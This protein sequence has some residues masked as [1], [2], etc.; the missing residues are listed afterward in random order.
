MTKLT[1][2]LA[3]AGLT[4]MLGSASATA[5]VLITLEQDGFGSGPIKVVSEDGKRWSKILDG[6][7]T[8]P[9]KIYLGISKGWFVT[10]GIYQPGTKI[11][12][13]GKSTREW[14]Q[15]SRTVTGST[16]HLG[17]I[18]AMGIIS[19]C[20]D[21]LNDGGAIGQ[22]QTFW[23]AVELELVGR[24]AMTN[25]D[26]YPPYS[27]YGSVLVPVECLPV[28]RTGE[29]ADGDG[30][31]PNTTPPSIKEA[32]LFLTTINGG[33]NQGVTMGACPVLETTVRFETDK[34]G[35]LSFDL[36]R[37][38]GG[39]TSHTINASFDASAGK[40]YA[41]YQKQEEFKATTN[42]QYMA[43][44]TTPLGGNTGWEDITIHCGGGLADPTS[45][46]P[47]D[48]LPPMQLKGDFNFTAD[49]TTAC[50]RK[51]KALIAFSTSVKNDVHYSL[52][53][54]NGHFSG[55]AQPVPKPGGGYVAPAVATFDI[56]ETTQVTCVLKSVAPGAPKVHTGKAHEYQCV[57]TTG[58][59]GSD[60]LMPGTRPDPQKPG[61]PGKFVADPPRKPEGPK[62]ENG[63]TDAPKLVCANGVVSGDACS[64]ARTDKKVKVG[65]NA[66]RCVQSVVDPKPVK[67]TV[68]EPKISCSGGTVTNGAC[69]CAR[70]HKPVKAG[71]NA[72][73]CLAADPP[74]NKDASKF[75]LKTASKKPTQPNPGISDKP[76]GETGKGKTAKKG[77]GG[78]AYR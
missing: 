47:Q 62:A 33:K 71:K 14:W 32:R 64:C 51:G 78:S 58:V 29:V 49:D 2:K 26:W 73:R 65:K 24:F 39:M 42:L 35:P 66:W 57:K 3:L 19:A 25:G 5:K 63:K 45:N 28:V 31:S 72:W 13:G 77:N 46:D 55:V 23:H 15:E 12:T 41:R 56:T 7:L 30:E 48:G 20:N 6:D 38:P 76:K 54:N 61:K 27:G 50:P 4:L 67:P 34:A 43:E 36:H 60:D 70:T 22:K 74:R 21:R 9:V 40:Y 44:S 10:Y 37:F 8:L 59:S 16:Q 68:S 17:G 53:C 69:N 11:A 1:T 18:E 75:E 52:D